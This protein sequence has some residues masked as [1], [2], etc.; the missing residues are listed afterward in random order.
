VD[1]KRYLDRLAPDMG[2]TLRRFPLAVLLAAAN[3]IVVLCWINERFDFE[4]ELWA[5]LSA[6][7]ASGAVFAV[8]GVAFRESRPEA[9]FAGAMLAYV[10]PLLV[11]AACL[12]D[13]PWLYVPYA[14][15]LIA[16]LW[17]S[18]SPVTRLGRGAE[19]DDQQWRFWSLNNAAI[20]T[21]ALA[22]LAFLVLALGTVAIER[23][24]GVLFGL[25][26]EA[27]FYRWVLP[28]TGLFLVPVYWLS[29]LPR[30]DAA[31]TRGT[32]QPEFI[33]RA[34]GFLGPFVLVP[35]LL[36]YALILLAYCVQIGLTLSLP[37]GM[38]GWMVLGFTI[39]G[40]GTWLVLYPSFL[41]G[42]L[43][44][45]FFRRWWWWLTVLPLVLYA[46]AVWVRVD[47]Y[48]LTPQRLGL[49]WGGV[50]AA[51]LTG[52][53]L[54]RLGDIRLIPGL[55]ALV[56]LVATIGPWNIE[57]WPRADQAR[58]LAD[59]LSTL[60]EVTPEDAAAARGAIGYLAYDGEEGRAALARII[61]PRGVTYD[62]ATGNAEM[63]ANALGLPRIDTP[64][65]PR[66]TA[67]RD[68][69]L[70]V[71]VAATPL[72]LGQISAYGMPVDTVGGLTMQTQGNRLQLAM[73]GTPFTPAGDVPLDAWLAGQQ[74]DRLVQPALDFSFAGR[75]YRLVVDD[76]GYE[77]AESGALTVFSISGTLFGDAV[78]ATPQ[79]R[80]APGS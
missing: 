77:L 3:T 25:D 76:I 40:A 7:L 70:P 72:Y 46:L 22:G 79:D 75:L 64:L 36:A 6:G 38:L 26:T 18:L 4:P 44:V 69:A 58:R 74:G 68:R 21:A 15:P 61:D 57:S 78:S 37:N 45:R 31:P 60:P 50:W 24:L 1:W 20:A 56:L 54:L 41:D 19:R 8:A 73:R 66:R 51:S 10:L 29:T 27:L 39:T 47:A 17:L 9:R 43:V 14:L 13:W 5:R 71:D 30:A 42:K 23:S 63:V 33:E 12:P 34:T 62:P 32:R 35:V 65:D 49:V 53:Y 28:A 59:V 52:L 55:A 67:I 11:V 80:P 16:V 48:G 2:A